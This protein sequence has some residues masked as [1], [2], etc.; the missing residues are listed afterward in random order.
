MLNAY[1]YIAYW[2]F[3]KIP[4]RKWIL[5][6]THFESFSDDLEP[7]TRKS[8]EQTLENIVIFEKYLPLMNF[9]SP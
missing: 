3:W 8:F 6:S 2:G 4:F 1:K 7:W 5:K 9:L